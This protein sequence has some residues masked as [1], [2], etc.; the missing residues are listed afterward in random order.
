MIDE[1]KAV[2]VIYLIEATVLNGVYF[3]DLKNYY[4]LPSIKYFNNGVQPSETD[5]FVAE[6]SNTQYSLF[7][8]H[9]QLS[10]GGCVFNKMITKNVFDLTTKFNE[11]EFKAG[12]LTDY[13]LLGEALAKALQN[14]DCL[15]ARRDSSVSSTKHIIAVT[16][17]PPYDLPV[18][19]NANY[20][21]VKFDQLLDLINKK[22]IN[23]SLVS[24]RKIPQYKEVLR[25]TS[26][27]EFGNILAKA[28]QCAINSSHMVYFKGLQLPAVEVSEDKV[29]L[30]AENPLIRRA[31][32]DTNMNP[33]KVKLDTTASQ[34]ALQN[35][36]KQVTLSNTMQMQQGDLMQGG[37]NQQ[38]VTINN[39][40]NQRPIAA[41]N[42]TAQMRN[43]SDMLSQ[44][45]KK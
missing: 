17:L 15:A 5:W 36:P 44:M 30:V 9:N 34:Q 29:Q 20:H 43:F 16:S 2:D 7:T 33:K 8:F 28:T 10:P 40:Q 4:I 21:G 19:R 12:G 37:N 45:A 14:F 38:K 13:C 23:L 1:S 3:E 39:L 35:V 24:G 11:L 22:G 32:A 6:G 25:K 18:M 31:E 27:N 26:G 41:N 42:N